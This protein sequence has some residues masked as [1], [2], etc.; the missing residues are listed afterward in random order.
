MRIEL[1][2]T[3]TEQ[4]KPLSKFFIS[5][6]SEGLKTINGIEIVSDDADIVHVLGA[7]DNGLCRK[8]SQC[9]R[10]LVPYIYSPLGGLAPWILRRHKAAKTLELI[11]TEKRLTTGAEAVHVWGPKEE[12]VAKRWSHNVTI[13]RNSVTSNDFSASQMAGQMVLLY[14]KTLKEFEEKVDSSLSHQVETVDTEAEPNAK[15]VLRRV[16]YMRYRYHRGYIPLH[17]LEDMASEMRKLDYDEDAMA[18]WLDRLKLTKFASRLFHVMATKAGLTE[19][20]M[21]ITETDDSEARRIEATVKNYN[22][23]IT[24]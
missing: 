19:G 5:E 24:H 22:N 18:E 6:L 12:S 1:F 14:E 16:A 10:L 9:R 3:D 8:A 7:W 11:S 20:F 17:E 23:I 13:I 4:G 15:T 2:T 21:P